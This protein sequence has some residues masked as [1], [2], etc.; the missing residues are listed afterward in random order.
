MKN[1]QPIRT[2]TDLGD[3]VR[4][5]RKTQG[6]TQVELA[7]IAGKSHVLLR[8]IETGKGS[9]SFSSVLEILNELGIRVYV[10]PSQ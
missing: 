8:D 1:L 6:L 9:V 2:A 4:K 7:S 3:L 5:A 10:E